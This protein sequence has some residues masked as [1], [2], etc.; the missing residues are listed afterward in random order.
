MRG[1]KGITL[2]SLI[3]TIIILNILAGISINTQIGKMGLL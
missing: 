3:V 2:V 1:V